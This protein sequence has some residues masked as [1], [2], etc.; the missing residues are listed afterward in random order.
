VG[1]AVA[2]QPGWWLFPLLRPRLAAL[3]SDLTGHSWPV[4]PVAPL[5]SSV[6]WELALGRVKTESFWQDLLHLTPLNLKDQSG[7][8]EETGIQEEVM[9]VVGMLRS[10]LPSALIS[11]SGYLILKYLISSQGFPKT[12][13]E[14]R[15]NKCP[16][17]GNPTGVSNPA[18]THSTEIG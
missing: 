4:F 2:L 5:Q 17:R 15:K 16:P 8:V 14:L 1:L 3:D 11:I 18:H 9:V 12:H 7:F 6:S 13:P 10:I